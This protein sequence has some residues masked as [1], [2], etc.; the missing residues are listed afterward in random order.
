MLAP[1]NSTMLA[2][3]LPAIRSQFGVSHSAAAWL[4]SSYLIAMAVTQPVGGRL[5]DRLGR[6]RVFR[7]GLVAFLLCSLVAAAAPTFALLL[8]FRTLQAIAG[9]ILIPNA[10]GMLRESVP[11]EQLGKYSGW[12]G[13]II[14]ATAA[15]GP[16]LG[17]LVLAFGSW[18]WLFL[19]NLPVVAAALLL[20]RYLQPAAPQ[21][22]TRGIV[23]WPGIAL[24]AALLC[25]VT[26]A[27]NSL[28]STNYGLTL[29]VVIA[30][31]AATAA[32]ASRQVH[33]TAPTAEW[34]LF[35]DRSFVGAS[36]GMLLL[37]LAMY[38]T[39]LATPFFL[40]EVQHRSSLLAGLI[41]GGMAGLQ[42]LIAPVAGRVSDA[43]GRRM[44]TVIGAAIALF[45]ALLLVFGISRDVSVPYLGV[46]L[47]IL[48]VG[49]G[50]GF[51]S[52]TVAA[53]EAAPKALAG[54]AAGTQSMMRYFGSIIGV[55]VLS[56]LL[57]TANGSTPG[58]A[59]FRLLFALVAAMLVLSLGAAALVRPFPR[60]LSG[61]GIEEV[62]ASDAWRG[63]Q[64]KEGDQNARAL[65][66][67]SDS[68][69]WC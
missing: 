52:T 63:D 28:R 16:L 7:G 68:K 32:F 24:F 10:M 33:G 14:G 57:T 31:V 53:I 54:S 51:V 48:G 36:S 30:I 12:N 17:G 42:A 4:V 19:A 45:A 56:G 23:D 44:P 50:I 59:V 69:R 41:L 5:G 61:S 62:G 13:A 65:S 11:P 47:A 39:L 20:A 34:R 25:L 29:V 18:R 66:S 67:P 55:G 9:A 8:V 40:V 43:T 27:L 15:G 6:A 38:T 21:R 58:I 26:V 46:A 37:N 1:L 3:A 60:K 35:R 64:T 22:A 49:V 2:V